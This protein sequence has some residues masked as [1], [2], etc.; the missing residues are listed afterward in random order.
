MKNFIIIIIFSYGLSLYSGDELSPFGMNHGLFEKQYSFEKDK[1]YKEK[2]KRTMDLAAE[3]GIKWWR[4]QNAFRWY[5]IQP[6]SLV[7][8]DFE[9]EDSLVK[10]TKER[11]LC[12]LPE[13]GFTATKAKH[14]KI[15]SFLS[16]QKSHYYPPDPQKWNEYKFYVDTIVKRYK[17]DIKY[18]QFSNEPDL[19]SFLGT[20]KQYVEMFEST[21]VAIKGADPNAKIV[22][23]DMSTPKDVFKWGYFDTISNSVKTSDFGYR[24]WEDA[25]TGLIDSIYLN[26]IDVIS[27]HLYLDAQSFKMRIDKLRQ[28]VGEDKPIWITEAGFMNSSS[29]KAERGRAEKCAPTS[30]ITYSCDSGEVF[31]DTVLVKWASSKSCSKMIDTFL[32]I[33]DTVVLYNWSNY[34][35]DTIVFNGGNLIYKD[36]DTALAIGD[37]L[38]I[39]DYW[40]KETKEHNRYKQDTSYI[41]LLDMIINTPLEN[42][43]VFFFCADNTINK[44]YY[45]PQIRFGKLNGI[46]TGYYKQR[47]H[48]FWSVI[49]TNDKP[50]PAYN[51]IK[52]YIQQADTN[53]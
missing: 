25:I 34:G 46:P 3:A 12:L 40:A 36:T 28:I 44:E 4:A 13:I 14:S 38:T 16:N 48:D 10:W 1:K 32:K 6:D 52:R 20:P 43:K 37:T 42:I 53:L 22:G 45:P 27:Q 11:G 24:S 47:K 50:Y 33:G 26:N 7:K 31:W 21:R 23:F 49:D 18:W 30:Y 8:W 35:K 2:Y 29:F 9:T 15:N 17:G 5:N 19:G 51:T 41:K 39:F